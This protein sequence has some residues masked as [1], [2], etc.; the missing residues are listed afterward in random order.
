MDLPLDGKAHLIPDAYAGTEE[1]SQLLQKGWIKVDVPQVVTKTEVP[2]RVEA[3]AK[4]KA[5]SS[6]K[7][8]KEETAPPSKEE[9]S[10]TSTAAP[11]EEARSE[12][13]SDA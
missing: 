5:K 13:A 9:A 12:D 3:V 8:A 4:S 11:K 7:P 1:Y 2:K 10:P 6:P